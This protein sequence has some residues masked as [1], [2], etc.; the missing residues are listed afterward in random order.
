MPQPRPSLA[1]SPCAPVQRSR[2]PACPAA[3]KCK[4]RTRAAWSCAGRAGGGGGSGACR[5]AA[6]GSAQHARLCCA[7]PCTWPCMKHFYFFHSHLNVV[8]SPLRTCWRPGVPA[9]ERAG[10]W[11]PWGVGWGTG[12][13]RPPPLR[14]LPGRG[15]GRCARR[16]DLARQ[17]G[18]A[19][20]AHA[21]R[22]AQEAA[23][24]QGG[25]EPLAAGDVPLA[26]TTRLALGCRHLQPSPSLAIS[27]AQRIPR[28]KAPTLEE[29]SL[30]SWARIMGP[31]ALLDARRQTPAGWG[32]GCGVPASP[33]CCAARA[34]GAA[35]F[36]VQGTSPGTQTFTMM[37][38]GCGLGGTPWAQRTLNHGAL[39]SSTTCT[40]Q[41][42]RGGLGDRG[43]PSRRP[44]QRWQRRW[45][46]HLPLPCCG[47]AR[48]CPCR[49]VG[50]WVGVG[51][52]RRV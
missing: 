48:R 32:L 22:P 33:R 47:R 5:T 19:L 8:V 51:V 10:T 44:A 50:V 34:A 38:Q 11:E 29:G 49:C 43:A 1:V 3:G 2:A 42:W 40:T 27:I 25:W 28:G 26:D 31:R 21:A 14:G 37:V 12:W 24:P 36:G 41:S 23:L 15:G 6:S 18:K 16:T 9:S 20:G 46:R 17:L 4:G 30:L 35:A 39:P 52:C 13:P 7:W 45:R